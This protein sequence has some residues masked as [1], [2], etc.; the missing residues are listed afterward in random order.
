MKQLTERVGSH[1][2]AALGHR[3][4][5]DHTSLLRQLERELRQ[6]NHFERP[7][8]EL[9]VVV[10]DLET[11]GFN[12]QKGDCILSIGAVRVVGERIIKENTLYS[13]VYAPME[14]PK[15]ISQLTGI[16]QDDLALAP[17]LPEVLHHFFQFVG[18]DCLVAHHAGH[19]KAFMDKAVRD[20]LGRPFF[21][22]IVD[23]SFVIGAADPSLSRCGLDECCA[24]YHI[25]IQNRHHALGDAMLTAQLW[26][27]L[28][29]HFH[30]RGLKT[31]RDVYSTLA[32]LK[33]KNLI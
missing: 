12:P 23:S 18:S 26:T 19:E 29:D 11:T 9:P 13:L 22:R 27:C 16:T 8:K 5:A 21:H 14:I 7:L 20:H 31:L 25:K 28:I 15:P 33:I 6:E 32:Q 4:Q 3:Q 30:Q 24:N 2:Y 10:F 17:K 1:L